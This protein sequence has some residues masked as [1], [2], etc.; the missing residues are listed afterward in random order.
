MRDWSREGR[1]EVELDSFSSGSARLGPVEQL[2]HKGDCVMQIHSTFGCSDPGVSTKYHSCERERKAVTASNRARKTL[3]MDIDEATGERKNKN[4]Y[5]KSQE[6][7]E[8]ACK[9]QR[10]EMKSFVLV[11]SAF[12]LRSH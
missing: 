2:V 6:T 4:Y 12:L 10:E 8:K 7:K 3:E 9:G 1:D 11:G 5:R